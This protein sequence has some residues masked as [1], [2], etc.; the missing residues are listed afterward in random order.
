MDKKQLI[1][2]YRLDMIITT[3]IVI[4]SLVFSI[5]LL[6]ASLDD[7]KNVTCTSINLTGTNC[8]TW[9][10]GLNLTDLNFTEIKVEYI[11]E[12]HNYD[13]SNDTIYKNYTYSN[14]TDYDMAYLNDKFAT[15][16]DLTNKLNLYALKGGAQVINQTIIQPTTNS[17]F[18]WWN[19]FS[20]VEFVFIL[21]LGYV[22]FR[23]VKE[24]DYLEAE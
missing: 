8:T 20:L 13:Y 14:N 1:K 21:G 10:D 15:K 18:S 9:W 12:E 17:N 19:V 22:L 3:I 5:T 7:I 4:L 6:T 11:T 16:T 23:V 24:I 2:E